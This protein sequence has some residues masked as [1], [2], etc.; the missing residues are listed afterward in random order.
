[1]G[2]LHMVERKRHLAKAVTYRV[3]GSMTSAGIAFVMTGNAGIGATVGIAD[4]LSKIG[5]YYV[6]ERI[7]YH[8]RWGVKP[9]TRKV[10]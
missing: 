6:H 1:M 3:L 8:V 10:D 5:L 9:T 4:A 7:W 2:E